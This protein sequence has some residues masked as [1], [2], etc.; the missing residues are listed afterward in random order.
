MTAVKVFQH[1]EDRE[2]NFLEDLD[3]EI[4]RLE[5]YKKQRASSSPRG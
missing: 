2:S 3:Q 1:G 5:R 4:R